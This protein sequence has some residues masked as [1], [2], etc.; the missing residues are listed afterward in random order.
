MTKEIMNQTCTCHIISK[1][2]R[3]EGDEGE[4]DAFQVGPLFYRH[5][6]KWGDHQVHKQPP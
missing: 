5:E 4:V 1:A 3:C 6:D 2:N